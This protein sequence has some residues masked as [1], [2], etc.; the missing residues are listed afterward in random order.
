MYLEVPPNDSRHVEAMNRVTRARLLNH[1]SIISP[2]NAR[3][4]PRRLETDFE[5]QP[6]HS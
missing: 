5:A 1:D 6:S 3:S 2:L 4:S